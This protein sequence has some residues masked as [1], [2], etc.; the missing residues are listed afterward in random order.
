MLKCTKNLIQH[1]HLQF[2]IHGKTQQ[3]TTALQKNKQT[4][5]QTQ[6]KGEM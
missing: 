2:N 3:Q 5:K 6:T 4:N 1:H